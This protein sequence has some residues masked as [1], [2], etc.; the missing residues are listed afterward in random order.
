MKKIILA[1][2]SVALA[3]G[4]FSCSENYD[5]YPENMSKVLMIKDAGTLNVPIYSAQDEVEGSVIVLKGGV[6]P[7]QTAKATLHHM[8][9]AEYAEYVDATGSPYSYLPANCIKIV[10]GDVNFAGGQ[11]YQAVKYVLDVKAIGDVLENLPEGSLMPAAVLTLTSNDGTVNED[12][13]NLVIVPDYRELSLGFEGGTGNLS[14]SKSGNTIT[15]TGTLSL[16]IESQWDFTAE[17]AA[18][19]SG[20]DDLNNANFG[21]LSLMPEEAYKIVKQPTFETGS[22]TAEFQIEVDAT[23]ASPL[24]VLPLALKAS[25]LDGL[26]I[27]GDAA[28]ASID[29]KVALTEDM[30]QTNAQEPNEGPIR[31]LLDGSTG[32]FFHTAWS[33]TINEKHWFGVSTPDTYTKF[34]FMWTNRDS[35]YNDTP[36]WMNFYVG[37]SEA[38]L[39]KIVYD[40]GIE[41][42]GQPISYQWNDENP[43]K[44]FGENIRPGAKEMNIIAPAQSFEPISIFRLESMQT[45]SNRGPYFCAST[46]TLFAL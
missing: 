38:N 28:L 23:K 2:A 15:Y 17:L 16:P 25:G 27:D 19:E 33:M 26:A 1:S 18:D 46:L 39:K 22:N 30:L 44:N 11:G 14:K 10:D 9:E 12:S 3:L 37:T 36:A 40:N 21:V 45:W 32:S 42:G 34:A 31:N 13:K 29:F 8:T 35:G 6:A 24:N 4:G 43:D 20:L 5:I 7:D 41:Y